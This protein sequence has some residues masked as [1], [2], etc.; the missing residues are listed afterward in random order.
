MT[1]FEIN[2]VFGEVEEE[3]PGEKKKS[4]RALL[5]AN[6]TVSLTCTLLHLCLF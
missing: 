2:D 5:S 3:V 6:I 4:L 1:A